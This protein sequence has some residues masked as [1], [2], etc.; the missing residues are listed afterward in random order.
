MGIC[1]LSLCLTLEYMTVFF[2]KS[3]NRNIDSKTFPPI[4][5]L[6]L[7][8]AE[9]GHQVLNLIRALRALPVNSHLCLTG[10]HFYCFLL[11]IPYFKTFL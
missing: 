9:G 7:Y 6:F 1:H 4:S 8:Q 3:I 10:D 5:L 11:W 2:S